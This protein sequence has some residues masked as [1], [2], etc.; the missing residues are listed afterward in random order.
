MTDDS[1]ST[2][3]LDDIATQKAGTDTK[4]PRAS[5]LDRDTMFR[6][7][8]RW[9]MTDKRHSEDWRR[10]AENAFDF[11][12]GRQ[13]SAEDMAKLR[14]QMRPVVT[15][16]R[17]GSVIGAVAGTEV[18]NRQKISFLPRQPGDAQADEM[19]T[20]T[21]DWFRHECNA[22]D[23]ESDAFWDVLVCGVGC[24]ETRMD[25][26]RDQEGAPF[27]DRIDPLQLYW[28]AA[29]DRPC[30]EDARR[31]FRVKKVAV[32]EARALVGA[33]NDL[34]DEDFDA[35]WASFDD[36]GNKDETRQEARFYRPTKEGSRDDDEELITLV[37][38]QW[39]ERVPAYMIAD[40]GKTT[41]LS[42]EEFNT[43]KDRTA[44]MGLPMP[45]HVQQTKRKYFR[46]WLGRTVLAD[47]EE[48]PYGDHFSYQAITGYRDRNK[49]T[50]Y[51]LARSMM[52]PQQWANKWLSQTM[53]IM[54]TNAKGGWFVEDGAFEDIREAENTL[55][56][57][58]KL[59]RVTK[60][61]LSNPNGAKIM[62]KPVAQTP[63]G[64][65]QLM[66]FAISSI[67]DAPGVN[68]E[69]L[70]QK[71][72]EQPGVLEMQ[73]KKLAMAVL[74]TLFNNLRR[75][76]K[77]KG[78][79]L[80]WLIQNFVSDGRMVRLTNEMGATQYIPFIRQPDWAE[81]DVIVDDSPSSPQQKEIAWATMMQMFQM[82][83]GQLPPQTLPLAMKYS[84]M[85][86]SAVQEFNKMLEQAQQQAAANPPPNP[87]EAKMAE[88]QMNSQLKMKELEVDAQLKHQQMAVDIQMEREKHAHTMQMGIEK[89]QREGEARNAVDFDNPVKQSN[90]E[91]SQAVAAMAQG[92]GAIQ[93]GIAQLIEHETAETELVRDPVSGRAMGARKVRRTPDG[94]MMQ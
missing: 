10:D 9:F 51:G 6:K 45:K 54:N 85:P 70:G 33:G 12:A 11:V 90:I 91:L 55:A 66:E 27:D 23:E 24:T 60:G 62:P 79:L 84:P 15:F 46:A 5:D 63:Q 7:F 67:R 34:A 65:S 83:K 75:Y 38:V 72:T 13:W 25:F 58:D 37:E 80:L 26:E 42:E 71:D 64:F 32:D 53:H 40:Q 78:K 8:K 69:L 56:K 36:K 29:A 3:E 47:P 19:L 48:A 4:Q 31:V 39:W 86:A 2:F 22:E 14:E 28:D 21:G 77:N 89:I 68:L 88:I 57:P 49:G 50:Y 82:T 52:D 43:L 94:G 81:Y 41:V 30:F 1:E 18:T 76:R 17:M 35:N 87:M 44:E 16:N 20:A 92:I 59:T 74:G 73:R 61:A 93:Q